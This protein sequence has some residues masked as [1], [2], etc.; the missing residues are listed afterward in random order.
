MIATF[1]GDVFILFFDIETS[2][3]HSA[4]LQIHFLNYKT[5]NPAGRPAGFA[6]K[7]I[8]TLAELE[9][10]ARAG[11][12]VFFALLHARVAGQQS[13]GFQIRAIVNVGFEQRA[14][15]SMPHRSS[16]S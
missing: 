3:P 13:F 9:T 7:Q 4:T 2:S 5:K 16:L 15:N 6:N 14:G 12:A 11:L 8:L 10:F 1:T